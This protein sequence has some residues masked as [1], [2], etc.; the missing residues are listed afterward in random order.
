MHTTQRFLEECEEFIERFLFLQFLCGL[1]RPVIESIMFAIQNR[2][3]FVHPHSPATAREPQEFLLDLFIVVR[4][5]NRPSRYLVSTRD[6]T[7]ENGP[8]VEINGEFNM[9]V[10]MVP[11]SREAIPKLLKKSK[12]TESDHEC[13]VICMEELH[14][15]AR[16]GNA[17][18]VSSMHCGHKFHHECILT[19][20]LTS[21]KCP[22]CCYSLPTA[23][24]ST[25]VTT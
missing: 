2:F 21:H 4:Y 22:L 25:V 18:E 23:H 10:R 7:V 9:G 17:K 5:D 19:W 12:V 15:G 6:I 20:L 8:E 24:D 16:D 14:V 11:T 3:Q 1:C 13:C